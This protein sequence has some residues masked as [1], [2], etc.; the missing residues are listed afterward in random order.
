MSETPYSP[1]TAQTSTL[2]LV[3]LISGVVS[4]FA[5][6]FIGGIIAV[7]TGHMALSELRESQGRLTGEGLAKVGLILGYLHL[8]VLVLGFCLV[9]L[10]IALGVTPFLC[11]PFAN[12]FSVLITSLV[13]F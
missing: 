3:S 2:A 10:L 13:G 1:S 9:A 7:V 5:I 12:Q 8:G 6:P 11:I 4:W